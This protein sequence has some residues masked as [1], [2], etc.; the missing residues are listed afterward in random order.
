MTRKHN[1]VVM[2]LS[3]SHVL[4]SVAGVERVDYLCSECQQG[5]YRFDKDS[6]RI[7][8]HNQ[9]PHKCTHCGKQTFFTIPYPALHYKGR[10]FVDWET[11]RG[12]PIG[13]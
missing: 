12:T 9:M 10:V 11:V 5:Y 2:K 1:G 7:K 8:E 6:A 3:K 13:S 4:K